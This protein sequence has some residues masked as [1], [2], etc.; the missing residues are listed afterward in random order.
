MK[1]EEQIKELTK[2]LEQGV[3]DVFTSDNFINYL[4]VMSRFH[5]YSFNNCLLIAM[6]K[7]EATLVAGYKA[8]QNKFGRQ[9]RKGEESIKIL[10]PMPRKRKKKVL[11]EDGT[12]EEQEYTYCDYRAVSVFDISQTDGKDL[13]E[14]YVHGLEGDVDQ[15]DTLITKLE[16]AAGIPITFEEIE[17]GANGYFHREDKRIVIKKDMSQTQTVKTMIH[18]V[19]HS[20]L[21]DKDNGTEKEADRRTKEVQAESVAYVV[22]QYLGLDTSGYSFG[23]V[24]GWS[25]GKD[26]KELRAS[27]EAIRNTAHEIIDRMA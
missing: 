27:L 11:L 8:W 23:Y 5:N 25:S 6:Q 1:R 21:H 3:Q 10:A 24:A 26:V 13:P 12:T 4:S 2:K 14:H 9:V 20:I 16:T 15:Y 22:S 7:P 18:E 17:G 19:A